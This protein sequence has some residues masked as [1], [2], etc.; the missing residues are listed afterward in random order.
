MLMPWIPSPPSAPAPPQAPPQM[1]TSY[2]LQPPKTYLSGDWDSHSC[3]LVPRC[4]AHSWL[5]VWDPVQS[6]LTHTRLPLGPPDT[7][8]RRIMLQFLSLWNRANADICTNKHIT[9]QNGVHLV[10]DISPLCFCRRIALLF[11]LHIPFYKINSDN[12]LI[13]PVKT[14]SY[15]FVR[16]ITIIISSDI[17]IMSKW[18]LSKW[19]YWSTSWT[20][21]VADVS[22]DESWRSKY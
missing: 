16:S 9:G 17:N 5:R 15:S 21:Q 18:L 3:G 2:H 12:H 10:R 20:L 7:P 8:P 11:S 19:I 22:T 13:K 6:G 1:P 4:S 14:K